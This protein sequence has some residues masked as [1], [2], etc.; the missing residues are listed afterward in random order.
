[1]LR[2]VLAPELSLQRSRLVIHGFHRHFLGLRLLV[3]QI[4]ARCLAPLLNLLLEV[5]LYPGDIELSLEEVIDPAQA[6]IDAL[7]FEDLLLRLRLDVHVG[8]DDVRDKT[9]IFLRLDLADHIGVDVDIIRLAVF[10][11]GLHDEASQGFR[12]SL[13]ED[14]LGDGLGLRQK[15]VVVLEYPCDELARLPLDEHLQG[16]FGKLYELEDVGPHAH[17]VDILLRRYRPVGRFPAAHQDIFLCIEARAHPCGRLLILD[18]KRDD[19][20]RENYDVTE[21]Q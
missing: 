6:G 15:H 17:L 21:Y 12:P 9:R 18:E 14:E 10:L 19:R 20:V 1:M 3:L 13:L 7:L 16:A 11:K 2:H 8:H 4:L 5:C